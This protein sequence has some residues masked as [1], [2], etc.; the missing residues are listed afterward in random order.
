MIWKQL[1]SMPI[2]MIPEATAYVSTYLESAYFN[3]ILE[4]KRTVKDICLIS[5][6]ITDC[7]LRVKRTF[8]VA[9]LKL[10]QP[11]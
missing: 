10:N 6:W 4:E 1:H 11:Q 9:N 5:G 7:S 2:S 3:E 8:L